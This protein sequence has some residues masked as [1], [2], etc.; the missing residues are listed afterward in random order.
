M[1]LL[2]LQPHVGHVVGPLFSESAV[3]P[4][5][6]ESTTKCVMLRWEQMGRLDREEERHSSKGQA[7]RYRGCARSPG[8]AARS[9]R[10][11]LLPLCPG[12]FLEG[13]CL[14]WHS[15]VNWSALTEYREMLAVGLWSF[16]W[17][18]EEKGLGTQTGISLEHDC[19]T[20]QVLLGELSLH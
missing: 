16:P 9:D 15:A 18:D 13:L 20:L 8:A 2:V 3:L 17:C 19:T 1:T 12:F 5:H 10:L 11:P 7:V 14:D 6:G 4:G